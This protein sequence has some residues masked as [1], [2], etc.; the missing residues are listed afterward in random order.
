MKIVIT[1]IEAT[2]EDLR[3]S[4]GLA[5][6]LAALMRGVFNRFIYRNSW[7]D[8]AAEEEDDDISGSDQ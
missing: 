4:N 7:S 6:S 1:E 2:S 8:D 3:A 5:D